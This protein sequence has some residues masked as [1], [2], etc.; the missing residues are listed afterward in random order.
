[1]NVLDLADPKTCPPQFSFTEDSPKTTLTGLM[2][3]T[4]E[5]LRTYLITGSKHAEYLQGN[6]TY[7]TQTYRPEYVYVPNLKEQ[8]ENTLRINGAENPFLKLKYGPKTQVVWSKMGIT[9]AEEEWV[10]IVRKVLKDLK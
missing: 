5:G 8:L 9:P 3:F 2:F 4:Y 7:V 6:I 10:S 1:M